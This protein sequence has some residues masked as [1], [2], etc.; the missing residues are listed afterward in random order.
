[1]SSSEPFNIWL[2]VLGEL[3]EAISQ[4]QDEQEEDGSVIVL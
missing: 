3:R 1:L 2:D 4:Q